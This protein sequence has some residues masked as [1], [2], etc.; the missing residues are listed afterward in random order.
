MTEPSCPGCQQRDALIASLLQRIEQFEAKVKELEARLGQNSSNSSLPPSQNPLDAPKPVAKAPS[1]RKP[2]GQPGHKGHFKTRLP[3]ERIRHTIAMIPVHCE[4]CQ[5]PLP[6]QPQPFDP[7]P[8][9][10][11]VYELPAF[12]AVVTEF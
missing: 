8:T 10:H 3:A 9:W 2:G 4:V 11:Q 5:A 7:E 6:A 1:R 12:S